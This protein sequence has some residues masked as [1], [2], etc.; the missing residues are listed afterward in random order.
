MKQPVRSFALGLL[1]AG[2]IL[3]IT[4][5]FTNDSEEE[6]ENMSIKDMIASVESEG[7]HVLT[8][9]EYMSVSMQSDKNENTNE[10]DNPGSQKEQEKSADD[11]NQKKDKKSEEN[12]DSQ[13]KDPTSEK[14][15]IITYTLTVESGMSSIKI[16]NILMDNG[17]VD[18]AEN[19]NRYLEDQG[20]STKVQLGEYEVTSKMSHYDIATLITR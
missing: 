17:I 7:Y 19:F 2:I 11:N 15:D 10:E 3:F 13:K 18:D 1:T 14:E 9:S 4:F 6:K 16:S 8:D 5:Y 20:Y 12:T